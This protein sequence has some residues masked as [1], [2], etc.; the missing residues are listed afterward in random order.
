PTSESEEIIEI[1]S[2]KTDSVDRE[3][4]EKDLD[5]R[6]TDEEMPTSVEEEII[7]IP[8]T[9][10]APATDEKNENNLADTKEEDELPPSV[11]E[12]IIEIPSSEL[13]EADQ[14]NRDTNSEN[15]EVEIAPSAAEDKNIDSENQ[16]LSK[17]E[18][19]NEDKSVLDVKIP[20]ESINSSKEDANPD[21]DEYETVSFEPLHTVDYFA[22]QGIKINEEALANDHLVKQVKSFTAWLKSMKK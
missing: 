18:N 8:S 3:N 12:E 9:E 15:T 19:G 22:S 21:E 11:K 17:E 16:N 20:D 1:P 2:S 5:T 13:T 10:I 4:T 6:N 14:K 7:E